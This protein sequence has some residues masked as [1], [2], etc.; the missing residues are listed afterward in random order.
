MSAQSL[1]CQHCGLTEQQHIDIFAEQSTDMLMMRQALKMLPVEYSKILEA[2]LT[3]W[4]THAL[5]ECSPLA[6]K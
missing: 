1:N 6:I 5:P 3:D 4:R 2:I